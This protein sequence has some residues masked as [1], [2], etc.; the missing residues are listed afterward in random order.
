MWAI[1]DVHGVVGLV[2]LR[3]ERLQPEVVADETCRRLEVGRDERWIGHGPGRYRRR[4]D[5]SVARWR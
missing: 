4:R 3:A 2:V 5:E 1:L